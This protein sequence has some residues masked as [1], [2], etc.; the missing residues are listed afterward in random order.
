MLNY[1]DNVLISSKNKVQFELVY[2]A[3]FVLLDKDDFLSIFFNDKLFSWQLHIGFL[4]MDNMPKGEVS[5]RIE[6]NK[7]HLIHNK[8]V[9][10]DWLSY[11]NPFKV[12]SKDYSTVLHIM[13]RSLAT[14]SQNNRTVQITIWREFAKK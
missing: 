12:H 4:N 1:V 8:W 9:A 7:I 11:S 6:D 10:D 5:M 13:L 14:F 2:T 3:T